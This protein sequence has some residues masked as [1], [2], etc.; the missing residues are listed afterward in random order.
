MA[1]TSK[2]ISNRLW[3]I[4]VLLVGV[5]F[6]VG[7]LVPLGIATGVPYMTVVALTARLPGRRS[8]TLFAIICSVLTFRGFLPWPAS[9]QLWQVTANE[10]LALLAI[11]VTAALV[12]GG[13][14]TEA[15]LEDE[16][17][18][19]RTLMDVWPDMVFVKDRASRFIAANE[20]TAGV[21][22]ARSTE[23]MIGRTDH[24]YHAPELADEFV[25]YER[26]IIKCGKPVM[27]REEAVIGPDGETVWLSSTK[28]PLIRDGEVVGL[29]GI[30]R[31][32]TPRKQGEQALSAAKEQA[33]LANR[34]KSEFLAN[35]SHELRTPLNAII[36]FSEIIAQ[37]TF[38]PVS[39][40][41]YQG[42]GQDICDAGRHLLDLINDILD[43]SKVESGVDELHADVLAVEEVADSVIRLLNGRAEDA[44]V[45]LTMETVSDVPAMCADS[46]K[47][48]QIL[49]N[50]LSNA[51]KFTDR[52]GQVVLRISCSPD[53]GHVFQV[54]D[55]GIGMAREEIPKALSLFGQ[56]DGQLNRK[57]EGTGLG[58]PLTKSLVE[59]HG[60]S[61][62][63]ESEL[64]SGTTVTVR[65]PPER[66]LQDAHPKKSHPEDGRAVS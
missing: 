39:N 29:I 5:I 15:A 32:I 6:I 62:D 18:L 47:L 27:G 57:Q 28:V 41:K 22:G 34:A 58:L 53:S 25:A 48:K 51:V 12:S 19:L 37:Q 1:I 23:E 4:C 7:P 44:G 63:F 21:M 40:D 31:D 33:E 59:M 54:C 2:T 9:E 38:G 61:L 56:V 13:N 10:A 8:T 11:W 60:G 64:G 20:K 35:M 36:G 17:T 16:R 43:L 66:I 46:R 50:L 45:A 65:F 14:K 26:Q 49:A 3:T 52:G 42:Y 24:D 30:N 55:T